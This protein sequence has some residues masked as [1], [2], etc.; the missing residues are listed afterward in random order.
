MALVETIR[1][2]RACNQACT[3]C[4]LR[5]RM[6]RALPTAEIEAQL[7]LG[8]ERGSIM[9]R[10]T[11]GEPMMDRRLPQLIRRAAALGYSSVE[12]ETNATLASYPNVAEK[13]VAAGL[14]RAWV[15]LVAADPSESDRFT[16]DPGGSARSI[17]GL[18][19]LAEGG[20][21]IGLCLPVTPQTAPGLAALVDHVVGVAGGVSAVR[22]FVVTSREEPTPYALLEAGLAKVAARCRKHNL[23]HRFEPAYGPPPCAFSDKLVRIHTPLFASMSLIEGGTDVP[24]VRVEACGACP[25]VGRCP[26]FPE[27]YARL[28]PSSLPGGPPGEEAV[29]AIRGQLGGVERGARN[30][31]RFVQVPDAEQIGDKP[32][33][34]LNWACNQRCRFCWVDYD[35]TPPDRTRVL[36]QIASLAAQGVRRVS[37][38]GGEPTL[39]P[40]LLDVVEAARSHDFERIEL[41][42]NATHLAGRDLP[43]RLEAAGLTRV[44]VSLHSHV[45]EV[46][47]SITQA[48]GDFERTVAGLDALVS[49]DLELVVNHVITRRNLSTTEGFPD[50]V[51]ARW[52]RRVAI[53]WSIAAPI[54]DAAARYDDSIVPFDESGPVLVRA[55]ERCLDL[56]LEFGGQDSSCGAPP[57]VLGGDPRFVTQGFEEGHQDVEAF[58]K[59]AECAECSHQSMCRGLQRAYV[60]LFGSRGIRP[61]HGLGQFG[62]SD[63][64]R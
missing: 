43:R 61:L 33:V 7:R 4:T 37:L 30:Q 51:H 32:N 42:T 9:V 38:T 46:S 28:L 23:D 22:L 60:S 63:S 20:V 18:R 24:R 48:P 39:V 6:A 29:A 31:L 14:T 12:V 41:Q 16:Q 40:W 2:H 21:Q 25:L 17:Q 45:A 53:T 55:L 34:R 1:L 54:T 50:F 8:R 62:R 26:G 47:D 10:F 36:D 59:V 15:T 35:W 19:N 56:G 11:G 64:S 49:T 13:L 57:C 44:L 27:G 3:F 58:V 52:G 5:D